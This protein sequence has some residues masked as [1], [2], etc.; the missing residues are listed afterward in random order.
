MTSP[1]RSFRYI[2]KCP[3]E[4]G[5]AEIFWIRLNGSAVKAFFSSMG[6]SHNVF[7]RTAQHQTSLE[8]S[9]MRLMELASSVGATGAHATMSIIHDI[10]AQISC[11]EAGPLVTTSLADE[12][13]RFIATEV[14]SGMNINQI[15]ESFR[16]SR[17]TMFLAFRE[18][19]GVGPKE[20]LRQLQLEKAA[21]LL[22]ETHLPV[23]QVALAAGF[24][25]HLQLSRNF[26]RHF[27]LTPSEYRETRSSKRKQEA[28]LK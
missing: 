23:E 5:P 26:K 2:S 16:V 13:R 19:F 3:A 1:H 6:F 9:F 4:N 11:K 21:K 28:K 12:V 24:S 25:G 18:A 7:Q 22:R 10:A 20:I 17:T 27:R 14:D 8:T 15:C